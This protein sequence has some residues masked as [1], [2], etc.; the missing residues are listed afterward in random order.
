[1]RAQRV[2]A[3]LMGG[4]ARRFPTICRRFTRTRPLLAQTGAGMTEN[5]EQ[6]LLDEETAEHQQDKAYWLPLR[7]ELE[8]LRH[9]KHS[10]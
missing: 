8:R 9:T 4:L 5:L 6:A 3:L 7:Q 10:E 2:R 1:M